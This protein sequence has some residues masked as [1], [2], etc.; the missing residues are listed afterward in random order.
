MKASPPA[1]IEVKVP[2]QSISPKDQNRRRRRSHIR[3]VLSSV[4][5]FISVT[6]RYSSLIADYASKVKWICSRM[7]T[8]CLRRG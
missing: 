3:G 1:A 5:E 7:Y 4:S 2:G 8:V 6:F